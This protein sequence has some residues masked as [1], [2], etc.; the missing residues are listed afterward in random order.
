M[1]QILANLGIG[2]SSPKTSFTDAIS[3]IL[4]VSRTQD[5][6]SGFSSQHGWSLVIILCLWA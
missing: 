6:I 1:D 5:F 2:D 3:T 4:S